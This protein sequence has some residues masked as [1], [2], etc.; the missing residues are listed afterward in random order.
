MHTRRSGDYKASETLPLVKGTTVNKATALVIP[1]VLVLSLA[2][3]FGGS[4]TGG[5]T[6]GGSTNGAG[7]GTDG[8]TSAGAASCLAGPTWSLDVDDVA[9][10]LGAQ[11]SSRNMNVV[12][13]EVTGT[14]KFTFNADGT[15]TSAIN[16]VYDITID[17]GNGLAMTVTQKHTGEPGGNYAIDGSTV[18]FSGWDPTGYTVATSISINGVSTD[19]QV[20]MNNADFGNVPMV[21]DCTSAGLTTTVE[22][23]PFE[24]HWTR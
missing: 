11:L 5:G 24:W 6:A 22:G 23:A 16:V 8:G 12:S 2:G 21:V 14:E 1:A 7:S 13:S 19:T 4:P 3:C 20:P 9:T 18:N 15:V 17:M 10:Q